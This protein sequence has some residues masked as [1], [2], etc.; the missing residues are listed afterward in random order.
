MARIRRQRRLCPHVSSPTKWQGPPSPQPSALAVAEA[1]AAGLR[2][3][4]RARAAVTLF[5]VLA[6]RAPDLLT[7]DRL[8]GLARLAALDGVRPLD[9]LPSCADLAEVVTWRLARFPLPSW[10]PGVFEGGA[11]PAHDRLA[12]VVA[13]LGRGGGYVE[14]SRL[15]FGQLNRR[16]FARFLTEAGAPMLALRRAQVRALGGPDWLPEALLRHRAFAALEA[17]M[18]LLD[19]L[20]RV[21]EPVGLG[22][23][24]DWVLTTRPSL[25]GRTWAS[26]S[27]AADE[28]RTPRPILQDTRPFLPS[29][30][31]AGPLE[32]HADW[33]LRELRSPLEISVDGRVQCHC[34]ETYISR[35]RTGEVSIWSARRGE[36]RCLTIEVRN[37]T[38][39]I[40][41]VRGKRNRLAV[42]E[43]VGMLRAWASQ[44]GLRLL[45][46][47]LVR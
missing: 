29:G 9:Q 46:G 6:L 39:E 27:R 22:H 25:A 26:A 41:Q 11:D 45:P 1:W 32:G 4:T 24:L 23:V 10:A 47:A 3:R 33:R 34:V 37:R 8:P 16:V 30:F 15:L 36:E 19:W 31:P 42:P 17:G 7:R 2:P 38:R 35:V 18:G 40:V 43:E 12:P 14:V 21:A 5:R 20:C 13:V 28:W 44:A